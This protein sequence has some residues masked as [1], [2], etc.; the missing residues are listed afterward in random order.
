[1]DWARKRVV[2]GPYHSIGVRA[3]HSRPEGGPD[4]AFKNT[5]FLDGYLF[6]DGI[7]ED[8]F[9]SGFFAGGLF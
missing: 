8:K 7:T 1:L 5:I 9:E 4:T 2:W 6:L 3:D